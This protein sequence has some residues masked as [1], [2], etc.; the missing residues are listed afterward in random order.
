MEHSMRP[1]PHCGQL[2]DTTTGGCITSAL[3]SGPSKSVQATK[4]GSLSIRPAATPVAARATGFA[5][6]SGKCNRAIRGNSGADLQ[7]LRMLTACDEVARFEAIGWH[8]KSRARAAIAPFLPAIFVQWHSGHTWLAWLASTPE[9]LTSHPPTEIEAAAVSAV[10]SGIHFVVIT[11]RHLSM[12]DAGDL[13]RVDDVKRRRRVRLA[14]PG[15]VTE[16]DVFADE[17]ERQVRRALA[18]ALA[19]AP[20]TEVCRR[21]GLPTCVDS[22]VVA[23]ALGMSRKAGRTADTLGGLLAVGVRGRLA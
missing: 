13:E 23:C 3:P 1:T 19:E 14:D 15:I 18:A 16:D 2:P 20:S 17:V 21:L 9:A 10:A 11:D 8:D 22:D 7:L 5:F 4:R 6:L 12:V